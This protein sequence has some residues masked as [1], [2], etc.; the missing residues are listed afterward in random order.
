MAMSLLVAAL[1]LLAADA[2]WYRQRG[3]RVTVSSS[4][5]VLKTTVPRGWSTTEDQVVPPA[6]FG[7]AC[8][9][10][11]EFYRDRE[12]NHF[13]SAELDPENF[14]RLS[15]E[16]RNLLRIGGRPAVM[17][18]SESGGAVVVHVY[19][20][21]S[22]LEPNTAALWTFTGDDSQDGL[23]CEAQFEALIASASIT[24]ASSADRQP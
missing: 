4:G 1:P 11:G 14:V 13:L 2:P 3:D 10:R 24:L 9:V 20:N 17:A 7:S 19:I 22:D 21:T 12:W 5:F 16:H 23:E 15:A 18:R 6:S 8:H